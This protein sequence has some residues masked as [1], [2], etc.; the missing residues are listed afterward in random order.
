M[1]RWVIAGTA[2]LASLAVA[3]AAIGAESTVGGSRFVVSVI[4][5]ATREWHQ[6]EGSVVPLRPDEACFAW[7][8]YVVTEDA[9][10]TV[11]E[12]FSTPASP[13]HWPD[14]ADLKISEGGRVAEV[15]LAFPIRTRTWIDQL[16]GRRPNGA[17]ISHGWCIEAGDPAGTHVIDVREGNR[18][19]HRFCFLV[20]PDD[21]DP[22]APQWGAPAECGAPIS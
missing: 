22:E 1:K 4:D 15:S 2:A 6:S 18:L 16:T 5:P 21:A 17:W 13:A 11:K 20:I 10:V 19:L 8:L 7:Q 14:S 3:A 12:V 9:T